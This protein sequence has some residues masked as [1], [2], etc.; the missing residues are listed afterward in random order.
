MEAILI[1]I[2][3]ALAKIIENAVSD[4][5]D[6]NKELQ[7]MLQMQDAIADQ[8]EKAIVDAK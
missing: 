4:S 8:R 1:A 2:A 7:A 6:K 3:P 5:Y